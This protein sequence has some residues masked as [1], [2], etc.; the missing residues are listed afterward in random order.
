MNRPNTGVTNTPSER[1][2]GSGNAANTQNQPAGASNPS[3]DGGSTTPAQ[4]N[5][6]RFQQVV[7]ELNAARAEAARATGVIET[8]SARIPAPQQEGGTASVPQTDNPLLAST[9][10]PF[11]QGVDDPETGEAAHAAVAGVSQAVATTEV[12]KAKQDMK[13]E[14]QQMINAS[15]NS[16]F[17]SMSAGQQVEAKIQDRIGKGQLDVGTATELRN[18]MNA[19]IEAMPVWGEG[20]NRIL[21]LNNTYTQMM[22]EGVIQPGTYEPPPTPWSV[23]GAGGA[24]GR[25][26]TER[27]VGA[28]NDGE[29][30]AIQQ[31][32]PQHFGEYTT[33]ELRDTFPPNANKPNITL[34][35]EYG[36]IDA[37]AK[38]DGYVHHRPRTG[39]KFWARRREMASET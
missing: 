39:A 29:L 13:A 38:A 18:R 22:D 30:L 6:D 21:L 24:G 1:A 23:T 35:T 28:D 20:A 8:L 26:R 25:A 17:T 14:T 9:K 27:D 3:G 5:Y 31:K 33:E 4:V 36:E 11:L 32:H 37:R 2:P 19:E 7:Q 10:A 16:A 15:L 34:Q 12:E